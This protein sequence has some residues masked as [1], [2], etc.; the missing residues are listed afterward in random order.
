[1]PDATPE[2]A[3][4]TGAPQP[5]EPAPKISRP[6]PIPPA[7]A[8]NPQESTPQPAQP[9]RPSEVARPVELP[10]LDIEVYFDRDSDVITAG[11]QSSLM[12]LARALTDPRLATA[13]FLI[14]GHTDATGDPGY[15]LRL[16]A[17]R[18]ESVRRFLIATFGISEDR[19]VSR[20]FGQ[21]QLKF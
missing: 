6:A 19:L 3:L 9:P 17:R 18:A 16:S 8:A 1:R 10:S 20:G 4:E 5:P 14:G 7:P 12:V 2:I 13:K 11:A 15:N 21:Q